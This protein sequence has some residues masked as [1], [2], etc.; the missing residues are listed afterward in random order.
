MSWQ[1]EDDFFFAKLLF[2][3]SLKSTDPAPKGEL[4]FRFNA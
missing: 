1:C 3:T 4:M 2:Q